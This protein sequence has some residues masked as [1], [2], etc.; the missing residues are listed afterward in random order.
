MTPLSMAFLIKILFSGFAVVFAQ[1]VLSNLMFLKCSKV[2]G[3]VT[4]DI[5]IYY[6]PVDSFIYGASKE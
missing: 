1:D 4:R 5:P 2:G 6:I 3:T